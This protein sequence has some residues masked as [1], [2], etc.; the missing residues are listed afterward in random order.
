MLVVSWLDIG[1]Y[2]SAAHVHSL[3]ARS[4]V[5]IATEKYHEK[6]F[7]KMLCGLGHIGDN[8]EGNYTAI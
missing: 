2:S 4:T 3:S 6:Q 5:N 7:L 8:F 1:F